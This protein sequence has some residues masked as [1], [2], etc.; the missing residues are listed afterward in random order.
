[1]NK[2][3]RSGLGA[4]RRHHQKSRTG[5]SVAHKRTYVLKKLKILIKQ[6]RIQDFR[7]G[8]RSPEFE[9]EKLIIWQDFCWKI[10]GNEINLLRGKARVSIA[11]MD[12]KIYTDQYWKLV[13]FSRKLFFFLLLVCRNVLLLFLPP[14]N[15]VWGKVI[16]LH[17]FVILFTGGEYLTRYTPLDQVA[18]QDQV[19]PPRPGTP[20]W[21]RYTRQDQVHPPGPGTPP[22]DQ[23]HPLDQAHPPGPGTPPRTR[24]T[25]PDQ[26]HTPLD[27]AH[28]LP[29][30]TRYTPLG[31]G[32]TPQNQVH[33]P[34]NSNFFNSNFF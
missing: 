30:G 3:A 17:L 1:M 7:G 2:A 10:H 29:P 13:V 4:R 26:A 6:W 5:V 11:T 22:W 24:H 21:T 32:T 18:P 33:P 25:P 8:G 14:A 20:P 19:H 9:P 27:Q 23:V 34:V 16:F 12:P 28:P 15:E 31:P